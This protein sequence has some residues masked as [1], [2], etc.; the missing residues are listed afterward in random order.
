QFSQAADRA[1]TDRGRLAR[2]WSVRPHPGTRRGSG[3]PC[4]RRGRASGCAGALTMAVLDLARPDVRALVPYSSAR[5]ESRA[6]GVMLN[7]NESPW[8][9]PGAEGLNRY[10]EPQPT[11]LR[12]RLA[13]LYGVPPRQLL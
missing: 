4:T 10:P 2:H 12:E 13:A 1:G 8:P 7:A 3:C 5:M 6:R 9:A 11:V